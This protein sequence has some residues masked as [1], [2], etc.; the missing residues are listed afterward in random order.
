MICIQEHRV[1]YKDIDIKYN[2]LNYRWTLV[3]ASLWKNT[4]NSSI[5]GI[6]LLVSPSKIFNKC[7]KHNS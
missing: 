6:G 5:S 2:I 7:R 4:S 3:T 1:Y